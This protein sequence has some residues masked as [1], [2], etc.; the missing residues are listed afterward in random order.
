M[1]LI[2]V[3]NITLTVGLCYAIFWALKNRRR[4]RLRKRIFWVILFLI[5]CF[6]AIDTTFLIT[7]IINKSPTTHFYSPHR[8]RTAPA[9]NIVNFHMVT[10][11][12][13]RGGQPTKEG[14]MILKEFFG[15]KTVLSLRDSTEGAEQEKGMVEK[16][17]MDF[18]NIP[19]DAGQEQSVE[20]INQVLGIITNKSRQPIFV[21]CH[22]GK[23]RTGLVFGAYR[24]KYEHWGIEDA[25][26]EMLGYGYNEN[27]YNLNRSLRK[28]Y[29][30]LQE[31]ADMKEKVTVP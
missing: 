24:I 11:G 8:Y 18:I 4:R 21:H 13:T 3:T 17:G 16:L 14:L 10:P 15:L 22:G 25:Y 23:D 6:F 19:M 31:N 2:I 5:F 9:F 12:I 1:L 7:Y 29:D 20:K 26:K 28:W 27:Y 30:N